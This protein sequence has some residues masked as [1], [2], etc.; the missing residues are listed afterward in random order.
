VE[1]AA[2]EIVRW[3]E[4]ATCL[5]SLAKTKEP[6]FERPNLSWSTKRNVGNR[7]AAVFCLYSEY[8]AMP[9]FSKDSY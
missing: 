5:G 9:H 2:L 8:M 4:L 1:L 6:L 7:P 3:P